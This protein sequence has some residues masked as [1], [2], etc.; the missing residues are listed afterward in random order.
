MARK[1]KMAARA[2]LAGMF[3][4]AHVLGDLREIGVEY[5]GA[6]EFHFDGRAFD[7]DFLK[8]PFADGML[9]AAR[10]RDHSVGRAMSLA[11]IDLLARGLFVIVI[12]HLT[13]AHAAI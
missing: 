7:S 2:V 11:W 9:I 3:A 8:I 6:V 10:G 5:H 1:S 12:E 13:L 4:V